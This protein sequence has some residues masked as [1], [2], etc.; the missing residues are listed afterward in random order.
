MKLKPKPKAKGKNK[1]QF[2]PGVS[3]NPNGRPKGIVN[4]LLGVEVKDAFRSA[5]VVL[6]TQPFE[7]AKQSFGRNP[8]GAQRVAL[9][10]VETAM[11]GDSKALASLSERILGKVP[12]PLVGGDEGDEPIR[13]TLD[14]GQSRSGE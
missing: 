4:N 5:L 9:A 11:S 13:F 6:L 7:A 1:G 8:T 10:W 2:K 14:I 12:Q 3:P